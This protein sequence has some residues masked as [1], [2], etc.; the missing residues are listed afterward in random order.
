MTASSRGPITRGGAT[1][2]GLAS[3]LSAA[4]GYVILV[5]TARTLDPAQNADF[6]V[7]WALLF[8]VF[9]VL[10]G[11]QQEATRTVRS[12]DLGEAAARAPVRVLPT[13]LLLGA[14]AAVAV[15]ATAPLWATATLGPSPGLLVGALTVATLVYAGHLALVGVLGGH[16]R[17]GT[18]SMVI[19]AEA[20][21]RLLLVGTV[22]WWGASTARFELASAAAAAVWLVVLLVSPDARDAVRATGDSGRRTFVV[23][24]GHAVV[25]AASSAALVVGFP[26]LLRLTSPEPQW[27]AAAPLLLAISLTR[28]PL[29]M[30]LN[31]Y[32]GVAL[33]HFLAER[34]RGARGL[35]RPA[36][37]V[38]AVAGLGAAA[39]YVA[40]PFLMVAFFGPSYRV[41]GGLL[42]GLT[43]AAGCLALLTLT[44]SA[45]L[46]IG[47]HRLYA[48]GWVLSTAAAAGLLTTSLPM[49][50]RAVLSLCLG[51]LVGIAVHTLAVHTAPRHPRPASVT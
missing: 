45:V 36:G 4:S 19:A 2:V 38:L 1:A 51:P 13:S 21:C 30:P 6:M 35:L 12:A 22:A 26:V 32:Q 41:G 31:A 50:D 46:A 23:R 16:G 28:A 3:V 15:A 47:R 44:G 11:V 24:T 49:T 8:G 7:F 18:S 34:A 37:A 10:G 17:W 14:V 27:A 43:L 25:A 39:A 42:A 29:L 40:G 33:T 48:T 9:G 5:I 20:V